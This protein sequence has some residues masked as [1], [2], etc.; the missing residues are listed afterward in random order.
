MEKTALAVMMKIT[1]NSEQAPKIQ[2]SERSSNKL[3]KKEEEKTNNNNNNMK[4]KNPRLSSINLRPLLPPYPATTYLPT[5]RTHL[6]FDSAV[7]FGRRGTRS[8]RVHG[9]NA[10]RLGKRA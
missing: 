2:W 9:P 8:Q 3:K 4:N 5:L 6:P 10:R 7:D 1:E